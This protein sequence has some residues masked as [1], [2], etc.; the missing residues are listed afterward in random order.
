MADC[1][2]NP[3]GGK[4]DLI[5]GLYAHDPGKFSP[6]V[7]R[8]AEPNYTEIDDSDVLPAWP[9]DAK[10][11]ESALR[12]HVFVGDDYPVYMVCIVHRRRR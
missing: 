2:L 3:K 7:E 12:I 6:L 9:M 5:V 10:D 11:Q 8:D 4:I 1:L